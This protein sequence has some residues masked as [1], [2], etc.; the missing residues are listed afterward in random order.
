MQIKLLTKKK[1]SKIFIKFE[2]ISSNPS[3]SRFKNKL[4]YEESNKRN[5]HQKS[6]HH[7][8]KNIKNI[9]LLA[10]KKPTRLQDFKT[11]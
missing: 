9:S 5:F 8:I 1:I 3:F 4:T 10:L 2:I 11:S 6:T 7:S